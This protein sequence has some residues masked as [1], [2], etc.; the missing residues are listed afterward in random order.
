[1][2]IATG[3]EEAKVRHL[4]FIVHHRNPGYYRMIVTI[5]IC[6]GGKQKT[7]CSMIIISNLHEVIFLLF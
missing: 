1:M 7:S 6:C 3:K 5:H 2:E 4:Q